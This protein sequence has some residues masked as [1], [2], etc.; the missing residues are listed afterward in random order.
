MVQIWDLAKAAGEDMKAI[1]ILANYKYEQNLSV[2]FLS[3]HELRENIFHILNILP[4]PA[5]LILS[6]QLKYCEQL[7]TDG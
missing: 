2:L 7:Q 5:P 4:I 3:E 1:Q 6:K